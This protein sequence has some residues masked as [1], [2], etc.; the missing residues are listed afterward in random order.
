M[1]GNKVYIHVGYPKCAST[2]LQKHLFNNH[3]Q[4]FNLGVYPTANIGIDSNEQ[5]INALFLL[6]EDLRKF[7]RNLVDLDEIEYLYS[8]NKKLFSSKI[9]PLYNNV[10]NKIIYSNEKLTSVFF[11][12][13]DNGAKAKRLKELFPE[14]KILFIIRNQ[15]D[16]FASQYRDHPFNPRDFLIGM[17]MDFDRWFNVVWNT[18]E[19]KFRFMLNYYLVIKYYETLFGR[20]NIGVFLVEDLA[21]NLGYFANKVSDFMEIDKDETIKCLRGK[22]EN[23]GVSSTYN[24][25]RAIKRK[26]SKSRLWG[27][28][29]KYVENSLKKGRKG[30]YKLSS[31]DILEI[32]KNYALN[33]EKLMV[34]YEL[35][36]DK[37]RYPL[38]GNSN[39]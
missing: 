15:L 11:A 9:E 5:D 20:E 22:H 38:P 30:V 27:L 10:E 37:Y 7:Y 29:D 34:D 14:A 2:T 31:K 18:Q 16:L 24:T 28:L 1:K 21:N 8:E 36:M 33:N 17:P 23:R 13:K 35:N 6:N 3:S 19:I 32:E 4:L 25:Y 26:Y 39:A 12:H